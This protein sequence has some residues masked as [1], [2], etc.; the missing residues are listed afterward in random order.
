MQTLLNFIFIKLKV[1]K[2]L[3]LSSA[4]HVSGAPKRVQAVLLS[5]N[6]NL[7]FGEHVQLGVVNSPRYYDSY[8]YIEAR[9]PSAQVIIGDNVSI[10]N[11]FVAIADKTRITIAD[12][13]L[14]GVNCYVA[15]SNFHNIEASTQRREDDECKPVVIE[16]N[17]FLGNDVKVLKG[18]TIGENSVIAAGSVVTAD[19]PANT[20]AGGIPAK[21]LKH[22]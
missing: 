10:N 1:F 16:R 9:Y 20:V 8:A 17:V 2:Y 12:Q 4:K 13:V 11:G 22:F 21:V 3:L 18:V 7:S 6:G 5:G 14:I 19:I 15:D